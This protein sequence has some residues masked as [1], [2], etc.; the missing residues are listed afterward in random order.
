MDAQVVGAGGHVRV[1]LKSGDGSIASGVAFRAAEQPLG[2]ALLAR[3]GEAVH[4]A[5]TLAVDRWGGSERA[6]LRILD[7]A[8][9]SRT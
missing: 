8:E 5:A 7:L 6:E 4:V 9:S 1:R 3:R 2:Q